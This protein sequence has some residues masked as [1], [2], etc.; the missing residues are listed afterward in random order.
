MYGMGTQSIANTIKGT[1]KEAQ[2]I[3]DGF[4]KSFPK[5]KSWIDKTEEDGS[6]YGYVEDWYGRKRRLP[7]LLLEPY[8]VK[9]IVKKVN[10]T[11]SNFNPFIGCDY[12]V[13]EDKDV[14]YYKKKCNELLTLKGTSSQKYKKYETLKQEALNKG[15]DIRSNTSLI[16]TAKRQCVNARIQ[17]G[18]AT[19]TKVAMIKLFNDKELNDLDF[20]MMIGVHDELIGECPKENAEKVA[21]RLS[22]IMRT[23]IEDYCVVPFKCDADITNNWYE[24]EYAS[25]VNKEYK[26]LVKGNAKKGELPLNPKIAFDKICELHSESTIDYLHKIIERD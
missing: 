20:H 22:Y 6:K 21:E 24:S 9:R 11:P 12:K 14:V 18:A 10:D 19:M 5:V 17:G 8:E 3:L 26:T 4:Y 13:E 7:D 16:A 15:I 25:S 1:Y 23:C 2:D